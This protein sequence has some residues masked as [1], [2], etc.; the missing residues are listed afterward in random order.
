MAIYKGHLELEI[1]YNF[2]G[3][4]LENLI[5]FYPNYANFVSFIYVAP[6][7]LHSYNTR[8]HMKLE[9]TPLT[10]SEYEEHLDLIRSYNLPIGITFQ[11]NDI[12]SEDILRY[13]IDKQHIKYFM[14]VN[15]ENAKLIKQINSECITIA[16]IC[17]AMTKKQLLTSDLS[18]YDRVVVDFRLNKIEQLKELSKKFKCICL[19][20]PPCCCRTPII[21]CKKHWQTGIIDK[22]KCAVCHDRI[23]ED[24]AGILPSDMIEFSKY[25][26]SFK[27]QG[28]ECI[29]LRH[30]EDA[31]LQKLSL[32]LE[33][34]NRYTSTGITDEEIKKIKQ[35]SIEDLTFI[36]TF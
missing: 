36:S 10:L 13:Y 27:L 30:G 9:N 22:D 31:L 3:R 25:V 24:F 14:T 8:A 6:F 33:V 23:L 19:S 18:M 21:T 15:D 16:S 29:P 28:R 35:K 7:I 12:L 2:D 1:P 5:R 4:Y 11:G 26:T 17:K 32:Y 34:A 20:N